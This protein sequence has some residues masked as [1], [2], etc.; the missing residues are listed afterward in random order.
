MDT[1]FGT[2]SSKPHKYNR[3]RISNAHSRGRQEE[4]RSWKIYQQPPPQDMGQRSDTPK[5][6]S[7]GQ[8]WNLHFDNP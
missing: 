2:P 6:F 8:I 4:T 1:K 7:S 5:I 3:T